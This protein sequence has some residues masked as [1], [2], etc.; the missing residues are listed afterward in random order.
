MGFFKMLLS[1]KDFV[2]ELAVGKNITFWEALKYHRSRLLLFCMVFMSLIF[3]YHLG[4]IS[5]KYVKLCETVNCENPVKEPE[6]VIQ[7]VEVKASEPVVV[8][9]PPAPVEETGEALP[10]RPEPV[11]LKA[12]PKRKP[13]PPIKVEVEAPKAIRQDHDSRRTYYREH[14]ENL[15]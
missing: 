1:L 8:K 11:V 14:L 13:K 12:E 15:D 10:Q 5:I 7:T 9:F 2:W 4:L 6:P 3:N